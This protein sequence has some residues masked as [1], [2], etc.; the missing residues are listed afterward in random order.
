MMKTRDDEEKKRGVRQELAAAKWAFDILFEFM[1]VFCSCQS[2]R[3]SCVSRK[4]K[5]TY[6]IQVYV[7]YNH[8]KVFFKKYFC[9]IH[10]YP[11]LVGVL[12]K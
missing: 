2:L 5:A 6:S 8:L 12:E 11:Y 1:G 4:W 7:K 9:T 3:E 10:A